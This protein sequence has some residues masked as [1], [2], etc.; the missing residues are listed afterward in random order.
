MTTETRSPE[1]RQGDRPDYRRGGRPAADRKTSLYGAQI[2][3]RL[4]RQE[5]LES[6]DSCS[7][8]SGTPGLLPVTATCSAIMQLLL[9][10][11]DPPKNYP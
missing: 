6:V 3:G 4:S 10:I 1:G 5:G 2:R 8:L 11:D 9:E 7:M